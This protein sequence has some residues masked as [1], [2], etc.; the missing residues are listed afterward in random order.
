MAGEGFFIDHVIYGCVDIDATAD[1]LRRDY[2]L[3]SLP[4]GHHL[5]G[6]TNRII[7][8]EPPTFLE[9]LGIGDTSLSDGAWLAQVLEG[10]DR[11]LWWALGVDDIEESARRRGLPV[12]HGTME[13]SNGTTARFRTAGMPRYPLPFFVAPDADDQQRV[14]IWRER[15]EAAGHDVAPGT[16]TFVEVGEPAGYLDA[17][18]GDHQLPVRHTAIPERG[19]TRFGIAT[20]NGEIVLE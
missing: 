9:L 12:Q 8:L 10:Q 6:T 5:G 13:M 1:R 20:A 3:G 16:F 14:R 17:W 2:G 18:L 15:Y 11:V 19:I 4:G 7:P